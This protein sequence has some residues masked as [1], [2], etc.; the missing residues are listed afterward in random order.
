MV[1]SHVL[2]HLRKSCELHFYDFKMHVIDDKHQCAPSWLLDLSDHSYRYNKRDIGEQIHSRIDIYL[3]EPLPPNLYL[4]IKPM[5]LR[6]KAF[7][8][9]THLSILETQ[10]LKWNWAFQRCSGNPKISDWKDSASVLTIDC[11]SCLV[12][13]L[14]QTL[15]QVDYLLSYL[16]LFCDI[17]SEMWCL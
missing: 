14:L 1:T 5:Q 4:N 13:K 2:W 15:D 11:L 12:W 10:V 7:I 6:R 9:P 17:F 8:L 16:I 3:L